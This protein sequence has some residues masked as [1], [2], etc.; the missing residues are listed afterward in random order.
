ML[1]RLLG[2]RYRLLRVVGE[3]GMGTVYE[4]EHVEL[5]KRVALKLMHPRMDAG[6][7]ARQRFEREARAAA[8]TGHENVVDVFDLGRDVRGAPFLVMELLTGLDLG[9]VIHRAGRLPAARTVWIVGQVLR[10][11][12]AVHAVGIHHRDLSQTTSS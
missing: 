12:E 5:S 1:G 2:K 8:A 4:A 3:G 11:L 6:E 9:R 7:Q 10:A